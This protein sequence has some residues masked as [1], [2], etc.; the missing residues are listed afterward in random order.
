MLVVASVIY[1]PMSAQ[2]IT[3]NNV[4]FKID[5]L[6]EIVVGPG[7]DYWATRMTRVSDGKGRLDAYFLRVD[8]TN[9]YINM[10]HILGKGKLI[11]TERPT[12]MMKR[13]H[14]PTHIMIGGTNGDFFTTT[15]DVGRPTGVTIIDCE[16]GYLGKSERS[17][18]AI[19]TDGLAVFGSTHCW[20]F[21]GKLLLPDTTL[22]ISNVNYQRGENKLVLF[23]QHNGTTTNTNEYGTELVAKLVDGEKWT[24][25]GDVKLC[26]TDVLT[27]QGNAAISKGAC[28]L[29]GHGTMAKELDKVRIGDTVTVRFSFKVN[30]VKQTLED[31]VGADWYSQI[32]TEGQ[33]V[34]S[35]F[36]NEIHPRT[37]FGANELGNVALFCV[38]DGRGNST[39]CT[40]QVL[41]E[42]MK[43]NGAW[44]AVNWDGGGSSGM[45]LY[46][47]GQMNDPS[48]AS[49]ERA[50]GNAM[51]A[52]ADVPK[53]DTVVVTILPHDKKFSLPRY[54]I[55]TPKFY[56]YNQYG[57][58][59][60]T[61]VQGVKLSC[62][63]SV[64]EIVDDSF[65]AS[66]TQGGLL[67][68]TLGDAKT[69]IAIKFIADAEVSFRLDSVL[70]DNRKSYEMEVTSPIGRNIVRIPAH[71]LTWQV[72]DE[73]VCVVDEKGYIK[74]VANGRTILTGTLGS[75][76]DKLIV[77]VEIPTI[78]E[79]IWEDFSQEQENATST[80]KI[81]ATAGFNPA[82]V[83]TPVAERPTT[84]LQ[85]T[86]NIGRKPYI[87]LEKDIPLYGLPDSVR[88]C[89]RSD[90]DIET[91]ALALRANHQTASQF[92]T[93]T[94]D[95]ITTNVDQSLTIAISELFAEVD[96]QYYPIWM[97]SLR[98]NLA[99]TTTNGIHNIYWK[100]IVL[101]YDGVE[102]NYLDDTQMLTWQVYPNPV[103]EDFL[104]V[105]NTPV[106]SR[107]LLADLQGRELYQDIVRSERIQ[108]NM[109][110]YPA[111]QYL[112]TIDNQTVKIIKQ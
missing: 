107:L 100:G 79:Y 50:V 60:K 27:N 56:G 35:G 83:A 82:F 94:F 4:P 69:T 38:V 93:H 20:K 8:L 1:A 66:G 77:N 95:S 45:F 5:T 46:N 61:D 21:S 18:G 109:Q 34:Q 89:F 112:L 99:T 111:G 2:E 53:E 49:G 33:V 101:Y 25:T 30:D 75:F 67:S 41:G 19:N 3:L 42:I 31:C 7:C 52:V 73:N 43:Y 80:W 90:A 102:V 17:L 57:V 13:E 24:T 85:F 22:K 12:A 39:G 70:I 72:E 92:E 105:M 96:R 54:G 86:Y 65:F 103:R 104:Q 78:D 68:A 51:F 47:F 71:V 36:W 81:S 59:V 28:V 110:S 91:V 106:G 64:G 23:N 88:I 108:I 84:G 9:P 16:Y 48:D 26:I 76:S 55:Y 63:S 74:G 40:T 32:L 97:K 98:F 44:N 15:G 14:T 6:Q 10:Q 62:D 87:L 29:S 11:G 37:G 58:M